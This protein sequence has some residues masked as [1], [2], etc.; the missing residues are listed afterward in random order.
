MRSPRVLPTLGALLVLAAC[1]RSEDPTK[2]SPSAKPAATKLDTTPVVQTRTYQCGD[3]AV[4]ATFD[5]VGAMDLGFSGGPLTL[6]QVEAASGARF[7]D[8]QGNEFW[9]KGEAATF[10]LAGQQPRACTPA[11]AGG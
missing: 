5:G 9:S 8:A 2:A 10:T 4:T 6:P 11:A 1:Q 3:L 7:A